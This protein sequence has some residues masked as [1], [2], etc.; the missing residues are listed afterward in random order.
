VVCDSEAQGDVGARQCRHVLPSP[1]VIAVVVPSLSVVG[2]WWLLRERVC[3]LARRPIECGTWA[4]KE[5][6]SKEKSKEKMYQQTSRGKPA[7]GAEATQQML[8]DLVEK[9]LLL[10]TNKAQ[11][12]LTQHVNG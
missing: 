9:K 3:L 11:L 10:G 12:N 1:H 4:A 2:P 7:Y 6:V 5:E 8:H